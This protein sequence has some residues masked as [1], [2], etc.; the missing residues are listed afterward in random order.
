MRLEFVY[1]FD[2][3]DKN[4]APMCVYDIR[5]IF[6]FFYSFI[7]F[8]FAIS[9]ILLAVCVPMKFQELRGH[10]NPIEENMKTTAHCFQNTEMPNIVWVPMWSVSHSD[11]HFAV[12]PLPMNEEMAEKQ[13]QTNNGMD[14]PWVF[15]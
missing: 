5:I 1:G 6:F 3:C 4:K 15:W 7:Y 2:W 13:Q 9:G 8:V 12:A 14:K 10:P 11:W